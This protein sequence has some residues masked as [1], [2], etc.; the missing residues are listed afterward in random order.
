MASRKQLAK[1]TGESSIKKDPY[2]ELATQIRAEYNLSWSHQKPKKDEAEVRLKL[3]NNQKRDKKAVGDTTMFTIQQTIVASLYVD[4]LDSQ[5]TGKEEGDDDVAENLNNLAENDYSDMEKDIMDYDWIWDSCFFGRGL[6]SMEEYIR[7]PKKNIYLPLPYVIDPI[8]FLRDPFAT[9]V[10]GDR[11]ARGSCRFFGY[12]MK[13]T[14]SEMQEHSHIFK[15]TDYKELR[16]GSGTH[17]IL[18]DAIEARTQAQG[19][20]SLNKKESEE[21][22][23]ANAQYDITLWYTHYEKDGVVKKVKVW[24]ANDRDK[25]VGLQE[26]DKEYWPI[27]DRPLYPTSHD[28]DGTSIPDLTEDKQRAR[29]A[30]QNLGLN[31]MKADLYPMYIYD[32]NK[33]TNKKDLKFAFN[34]FIPVDARG[35]TIAGAIAPLIKARPNMQLLDFIYNSL[36]ISAQKATATPEIQQGQLSQQQRTLGEINIVASKVD[37]RYSLSAKIFGWSERRFWQH[38][39]W[40]YKENFKGGIDKKVL[41]IEGAFG[42]KWRPLKKDDII[43][44]IDPD[45]KIESRVLSRA[46]QLEERQALTAYFSLA[47]QE[48]TANRRW[49]LKKLAKLNGLKKDEIDRLFPPVVD[50]RIAEEQNDLLNK[51]KPVP[52]L[53]EDDHNIHLEVHAKAKETDA[54]FAHIRTHVEAL[55]VKKVSPELFPEE[56]VDQG[57]QSPTGGQQISI[58]AGTTRGAGTMRPSESSNQPTQAFQ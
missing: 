31:A 10:N 43:A 15:E 32:S 1:E 53:R 49:G 6:V 30:A 38:W 55:S 16:F 24:L 21:L 14:K 28:W 56:P 11:K 39:Y 44:R 37:T 54:T 5:W 47:L 12:E 4:R 33:V 3:Y 7:E 52:V 19:L 41:R 22:L 42:A 58:P 18:K 36:D 27:I 8:P 57:F 51:N 20:Q 35:E 13:M 2:E 45:V 26:L 25:V 50:E 46:N 9:S 40:S 23:G 34:K 29:A 17:S 48:P